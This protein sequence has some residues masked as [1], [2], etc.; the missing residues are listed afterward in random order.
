MRGQVPV[1]LTLLIGMTGCADESAEVARV[2]EQALRQQA[3]QNE[4]M[5]QLNHEIAESTQRLVEADTEARREILEAQRE[6]QAQQDGVNQQRDALEQE[7]RDIS[8][9][10]R[11]E[12]VLAPIV[13]TLGAGL[14]CLLP[15]VIAGQML[16][17]VNR[18]DAP[19]VAELL[20]DDALS[21]YSRLTD[22]T[23][24]TRR[25]TSTK[26]VATNRLMRP[27]HEDTGVTR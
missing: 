10:R 11:T 15:V 24:P 14:L 5:S 13:T 25:I 12:S 20:L 9:L 19:D 22:T 27:D 7:R 18:S 4:A 16:W 2:A 17:H 23:T 26:G 1:M 6:I 21:D 3:Q 8:A